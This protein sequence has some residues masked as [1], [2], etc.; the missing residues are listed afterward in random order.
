MTGEPRGLFGE[1]VR[2][3][4]PRDQRPALDDVPF[5]HAAERLFARLL[6]FYGIDWDYEPRS[7]DLATDDQGNVTDAFTPD[8]YLPEYDLYVEITTMSQKLVTRK[9]RKLRLLGERHPDVRC[10]IFYQRDV[11]N[12]ATKLGLEIPTEDYTAQD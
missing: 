10:R 6:E 2:Q 8:F 12:L 9:N 4:R 11:Y 5:V 1:P 3:A 7:F